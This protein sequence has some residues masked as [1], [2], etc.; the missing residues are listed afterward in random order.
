MIPLQLSRR[1][2]IFEAN[3]TV[4]EFS[5]WFMLSRIV[6]SWIQPGICFW[7]GRVISLGRQ[8]SR[9][10][11]EWGYPALQSPE[12]TRVK[13]IWPV[14]YL[15]FLNTSSLQIEYSI[16]KPCWPWSQM[17]MKKGAVP[18]VKSLAP[19]GSLTHPRDE[20]WTPAH[21][22]G[23]VILNPVLTKGLQKNLFY[24]LETLSVRRKKCPVGSLFFDF[25]RNVYK[26]MKHILDYK[27]NT[28][29]ILQQ[30]L[31]NHYWCYYS[32][33]YLNFRNPTF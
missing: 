26:I 25:L 33:I 7:G 1:K 21:V 30:I 22:Q 17:P 12:E 11:V 4:G 29:Y 28:D 13:M 27:Q 19:A 3:F 5:N 8:R 24:M 23:R 14:I 18:T 31:G 9:S 6:Y 10:K 16:K 32:L 20:M 15:P 2:E